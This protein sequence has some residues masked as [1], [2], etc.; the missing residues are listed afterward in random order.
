MSVRSIRDGTAAL[1]ALARKVHKAADPV[2]LGHIQIKGQPDP[3]AEHEAA[4]QKA[5][6]RTGI[7][8]RALEGLRILYPNFMLFVPGRGLLRFGKDL[9]FRRFFCGDRPLQLGRLLKQDL[10]A[11]GRGL[12]TQEHDQNQQK[13]EPPVQF[14]SHGLLLL[15]LQYYTAALRAPPSLLQILCKS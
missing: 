5:D 3:V 11:V 14:C 8:L 1:H 7:L 6:I 9:L 4:A 13:A 15:I 10:L 12:Y 2:C